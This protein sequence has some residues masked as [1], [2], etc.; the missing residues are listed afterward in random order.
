MIL[1][2]LNILLPEK[3]PDQEKILDLLSRIYSTILI[4]PFPRVF[5]LFSEERRFLVDIINL[6]KRLDRGRPIN[7]YHPRSRQIRRVFKAR[8]WKKKTRINE[9]EL[10]NEILDPNKYYIQTFA[11]I[12]LFYRANDV[13]FVKWLIYTIISVIATLGTYELINDK[14]DHLFDLIL[15][16]NF[17]SSK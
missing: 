15:K 1:D 13:N 3:Y 2:L 17:W 5:L 12:H 9:I 16:I 8:R 6:T 11:I 4:K 14:L 7:K 10:R